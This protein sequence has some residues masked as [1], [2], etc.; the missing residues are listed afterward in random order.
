MSSTPT[1]AQVAATSDRGPCGSPRPAN[2]TAAG[3]CPTMV[4]VTDVVVGDVRVSGGTVTE[5]RWAKSRKSVEIITDGI[6][7]ERIAP[8]R[9]VTLWRR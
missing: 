2:M 8:T 6:G 7:S 9:R 3:F 1:A 4:A 5:L